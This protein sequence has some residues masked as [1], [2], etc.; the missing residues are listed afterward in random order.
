MENEA[1]S[2]LYFGTYDHRGCA[3]IPI[4]DPLVEHEVPSELYFGPLLRGVLSAQYPQCL[5]KGGVSV[6]VEPPWSIEGRWT[7]W[8][9][10][11]C[12]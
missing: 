12:P 1:P 3:P 5:L 4:E 7:A 2:E 8:S 9:S 6:F 10:Q 11:T